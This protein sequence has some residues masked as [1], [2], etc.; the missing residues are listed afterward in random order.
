[1]ETVPRGRPGRRTLT[2]SELSDACAVIAA[3]ASDNSEAQ[4]PIC[5][6]VALVTRTRS[7]GAISRSTPRFDANGA[8]ELDLGRGEAGANR[9]DAAGADIQMADFAVA[10]LAFGESDSE[11]GCLEQRA[12]G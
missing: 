1:M 2:L 6:V 5:A 11:T 8:V 7:A 10:H 3:H 4:R 9:F 12:R